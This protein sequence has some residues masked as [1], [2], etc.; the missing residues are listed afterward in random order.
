[1]A[2]IVDLVMTPEMGAVM[3]EDGELKMVSSVE[4]KLMVLLG[5]SKDPIVWTD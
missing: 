3:C 2:K 4:S 5:V 1:M